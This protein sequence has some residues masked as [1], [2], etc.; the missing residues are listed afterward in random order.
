[1]HI[2]EDFKSNHPNLDRAI[3]FDAPYI[4]FCIDQCHEHLAGRKVQIT[5]TI[6][7]FETLYLLR[8]FYFP[9]ISAFTAIHAPCSHLLLAAP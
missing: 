6:V 5:G 9:I 3:I 8:Q 1:M 7:S 4:S 2:H